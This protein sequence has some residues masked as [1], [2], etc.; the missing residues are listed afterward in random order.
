MLS[1]DSEPFVFQFAIQKFLKIDIYCNII[2]PFDLYGC[3]T[4]S[5]TLREECRLREFKNRVLR[6]IF[7]PKRDKATGE[8]RKQHNEEL[9]DLHSSPNIV[10]VII[11]KEKI[12]MGGVCSTQGGE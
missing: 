6:R 7:G 5:L 12:E 9:N 1:F 11:S 4:W 2:L 10:R 3:G 8:W